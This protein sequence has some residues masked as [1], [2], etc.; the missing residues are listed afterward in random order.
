M[1]LHS[2]VVGVVPRTLV[3]VAPPVGYPL[4]LP[5]PFQAAAQPLLHPPL[6]S[7]PPLGLLVVHPVGLVPLAW[8]ALLPR[9][10]SS[11]SSRPLGVGP[12][13]GV[14]AF[15]HL[16]GALVPHL[17]SSRHRVVPPLLA[18]SSSPPPLGVGLAALP[19]L[20]APSHLSTPPRPWAPCPW[21][22]SSSSSNP[23]HPSLE[24]VPPLEVHP[25]AVVLPLQL[26]PQ[27]LTLTF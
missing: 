21:V 26:L 18:P 13:A 16:L 2:K 1:V 22:G 20:G 7:S 6:P 15:P 8:V 4:E 11:S 24:G 3:V 9:A 17:H 14:A 10:S 23:L 25:L 27:G 12:L 5:S 19:G